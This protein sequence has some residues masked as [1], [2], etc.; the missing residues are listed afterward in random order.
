MFAIQRPGAEGAKPGGGAEMGGLVWEKRRGRGEERS[1]SYRQGRGLAGGQKQW[2]RRETKVGEV[3]GGRSWGKRREAVVW[4][5]REG[6]G[7]RRPAGPRP[8]RQ[9]LLPLRMWLFTGHHPTPTEMQRWPFWPLWPFLAGLQ[10]HASDALSTGSRPGG[11]SRSLKCHLL[12]GL[13]PS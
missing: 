4:V 10:P 7:Q 2:G 12:P 13:F 3:G 8:E 9:P 6:A 1:K 5:G 11:L